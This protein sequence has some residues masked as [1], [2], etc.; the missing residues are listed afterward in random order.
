MLDVKAD[1]SPGAKTMQV[2][3]RKASLSVVGNNPTGGNFWDGFILVM[4]PAP[5]AVYPGATTV[6]PDTLDNAKKDVN[7]YANSGGGSVWWVLQLNAGSTQ[8]T[9]GGALSDGAWHTYTYDISGYSTGQSPVLLYY[10]NR[11][12]PTAPIRA[13]HTKTVNTLTAA[14]LGMSIKI[15]PKVTL[16]SNEGGTLSHTGERY[17]TYGTSSDTY[18]W[19][20]SDGYYVKDVKIDGV[21]QGTPASYSFSNITQNHTVYVEFARIPA[22]ITYDKNNPDA[23]GDTP[24]TTG[25]LYDTAT[26]SGNAF[27]S[28]L[29]EFSSWN[30]SPD[31]D[32]ETYLPG[33]AL[34]L[35]APSATLYA[36]W[37]SKMNETSKTVDHIS[38]NPNAFMITLTVGG[39]T[40]SNGNISSVYIEDTL[41]EYVAP[42]FDPANPLSPSESS[43]M[44]I[45]AV[46]EETLLDTREAD[47]FSSIPVSADLLT[48]VYDESSHSISIRYIGELPVSHSLIIN[49][50]VKLAPDAV[51]SF[52]AGDP[53]PDIGETGTG[54]ISEGKLGYATNG[55]SGKD[56]AI[57]TDANNVESHPCLLP[58]PAVEPIVSRLVYIADAPDD[59]I[60]GDIPTF[61]AGGSEKVPIADN[62][63]LRTGYTFLGWS[64]ISNEE[65]SGFEGPGTRP[66]LQPGEQITLS[67]NGSD[68]ILYAVWEKNPVINVKVSGHGTCL[69]YS[70]QPGD[71]DEMLIGETTDGQESSYALSIGDDAKLTWMPNDAW[72]TEAVIIDGNRIE[73]KKNMENGESETVTEYIL[74]NLHGEHNVEILFSPMLDMPET[75]SPGEM[76]LFSI[77]IAALIIVSMRFLSGRVRPIRLFL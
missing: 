19:I 64:T 3:Y 42:L 73:L 4:P 11:N 32:G 49:I 39:E 10:G 33:D 57:I 69:I 56:F 60:M 31:G 54:D 61:T 28:N 43:S 72:W 23:S 15:A 30:T 68:T 59:E 38:D 58:T 14:T 62:A 46:I 18:T 76:F 7:T 37:T 47:K 53:L 16:S 40:Y 25:L 63:F 26:V 5:S 24:P 48:C 41:S 34:Y 6:G 45:S 71:A 2:S 8:W 70:H 9:Q 77:G 66:I 1:Y 35:D 67:N 13:S 55:G 65:W 17:Y 50:P 12:W 21:S 51:S 75:G 27:S 44:P 20:P 74:S 36:Q 29:Y 22:M 52:I